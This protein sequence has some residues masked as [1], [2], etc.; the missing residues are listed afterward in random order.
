MT[1][2][3]L[4]VLTA[5][6]GPA[7]LVLRRGP[8]RAVAAIGWD[9]ESGAVGLGQWLRGRIYEYR[10]DI[11]PDGRHWIYF[12]ARGGCGWT[13]LARVP[14]LRALAFWPQGSTWCGG[15]AFDAR[16]RLWLNGAAAPE[17]LPDGLRPAPP[18][19]YPH[20]TDG[21]SGGSLYPAMLERRGWRREGEGYGAALS[22]DLPGGGRI[23]LSFVVGA[24]SRAILSGRYAVVG[25]DG[26]RRE[27]PDWEWADLWGDRLQVAAKGAL[28][29]RPAAGGAARRLR[30]LS[31]MAFEALAAPY[32]GV[33]R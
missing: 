14:W 24:R 1:P 29:E 22:R 32:E 19:A 5:P 3:R 27:E 13:A 2:P 17:G 20:S 6:G 28:W 31:G 21:L 10:A 33:G 26:A 12:A 18:D 4:H 23:E 11:S 8:S 30:D 9:R 25:P 16:G 15:G 7:A